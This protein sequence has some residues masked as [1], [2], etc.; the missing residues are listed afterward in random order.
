V[1]TASAV[2]YMFGAVL[3]AVGFVCLVFGANKLLSP[4]LPTSQKAEPYECGMDQQGDPHRAVTPRY[5]AIAVLFVLFDAEAVLLFAV[6]PRLHGSPAAFAAIVAFS[7]FLAFGLVY[8]W[9]KGA[10]SWR[11]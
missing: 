10:L 3:A 7:V 8:A 6:A 4:R 5:A 2:F 11:W 9:R 1:S